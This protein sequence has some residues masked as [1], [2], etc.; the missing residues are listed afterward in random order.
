MPFFFP[1]RPSRSSY[2]V[3]V[4]GVPERVI[5]RKAK[6][7]GQRA[8]GSDEVQW[9][10]ERPVE[11]AATWRSN[12]SSI[13]LTISLGLVS[14]GLQPVLAHHSVVSSLFLF[15]FFLRYTENPAFF[16]RSIC[17]PPHTRHRNIRCQRSR[18]LLPRDMCCA[19]AESPSLKR[20]IVFTALWVTCSVPA[21]WYS[22]RICA[23]LFVFHRFVLGEFV[24]GESPFLCYS[25]VVV[26][27]PGPALFVGPL[28]PFPFLSLLVLSG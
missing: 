10:R 12:P 20:Q 21:S 27:V 5:R 18:A 22:R 14:P 25:T 3:C 9:W 1:L 26:F 16:L 11:E 17:L 28:S 19:S 7:K 4:Y 8:S 24:L 6:A 13:H 15:R 23:F 2:A